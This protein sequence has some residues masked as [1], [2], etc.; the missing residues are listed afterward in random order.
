M[1]WKA[2]GVIGCI[3]Y[4]YSLIAFVIRDA[5]TEKRLKQL[6]SE[7]DAFAE[8]KSRIRNLNATFDKIEQIE[9]LLTDIEICSPGK[10]HKNFILHWNGDEQYDFLLDGD[11]ITTERFHEL[12]EA[13]YEK[14]RSS[15]LEQ[16]Q[17]LQ[18]T[19]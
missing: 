14:L 7:T 9:E 17:E 15:L 3:Y 16:I 18:D 2:I 5:Q 10:L 19:P 12:A 6:K 8:L 13:E 1:I 4:V 11:D